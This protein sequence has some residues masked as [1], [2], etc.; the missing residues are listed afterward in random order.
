YSSGV[1]WPDAPG[2][3]G[4]TLALRNPGL[5][6]TL[7]VNWAAS[8]L[9]GTPGEKNDVFIVGVDDTDES[10]IPGVFTLGQ[11]YPNPFNQTTIIPFYVPEA[12]RVTIEIYSILG[13]RVAKILDEYMPPGH[14]TVTF[15]AP[16]FSNGFFFYRMN[17][18]TFHAT[19][20]MLL[21]K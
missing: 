1:P 16:E 5:D 12:S 4:P 9:Y 11:N 3:N 20:K 14:H 17:A 21:L 18:D 15:N 6:N 8:S 13:Q 7:S 2:G 10:N 19:G